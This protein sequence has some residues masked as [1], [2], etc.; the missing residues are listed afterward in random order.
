MTLAYLPSPGLL[1]SQ[2]KAEEIAQHL[3]SVRP[4]NRMYAPRKIG[5]NKYAMVEI[6]DPEGYSIG[7]L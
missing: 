1:L 7:Y 3:N 2:Q 4:E 5:K 6:F